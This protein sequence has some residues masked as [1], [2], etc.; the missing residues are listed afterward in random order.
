M[1]IAPVADGQ[2]RLR[3]PDWF[4][5]DLDVRGGSFLFSQVSEAAVAGATFMDQRF[6]IDWSRQQ[7]VAIDEVTRLAPPRLEMAWLWHTSFC[8][9]TLLA[10]ALGVEPWTNVLREPL[11]L[12]RLSDARDAGYAVADATAASVALLSRRWHEHGK[13]VVKPTHA[14]LNI[15]REV[16]ASTPGDRAIVL[17]SPLDDFLVSNLKKS[18]ETQGKAALLA[19]RALRAGEFHRRLSSAAFN[20]PDHL[21]AAALQWA[22]QRELAADLCTAAGGA[23]HVVSSRDLFADLAGTALECAGWLRLGIPETTLRTQCA[24]ISGRHA[25]APT[26]AY[27]AT[28]RESEKAALRASHGTQITSTRAWAERHVLPFMQPLALSMAP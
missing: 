23:V 21:C 2:S 10:R 24:S 15:V 11:L 28:V 27:D 5:V 25:K 20:P 7:R 17:T 14:A 19:E 4:P 16:L 26:R 6:D 22:A 1:T 8:G 3:D 9:S 12:R 18:Q 13:I